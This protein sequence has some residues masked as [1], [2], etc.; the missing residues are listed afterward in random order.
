MKIWKII[1]TNS[2]ASSFSLSNWAMFVCLILFTTISNLFFFS[3]FFD[4]WVDVK[5]K[6]V[7]VIGS[8]SPW[9]EAVLLVKGAA[10]I[11]TFDY[12]KIFSQHPQLETI[13]PGTTIVGIRGQSYQNV[14]SSRQ[15]SFQKTVREK[16]YYKNFGVLKSR[17]HL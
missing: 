15:K 3:E 17:F 6:S 7:L 13:T 4:Q 5:N 12:I 8:Q 14:S 9:L 10:W 1:L 16:K 11:T 2:H